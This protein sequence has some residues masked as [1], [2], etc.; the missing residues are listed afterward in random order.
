MKMYSYGISI[1][2]Y[3]IKDLHMVMDHF[4]EGSRINEG[5]ELLDMCI[6]NGCSKSN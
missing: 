6:I 1:C 5:R 2:R 4:G 3:E